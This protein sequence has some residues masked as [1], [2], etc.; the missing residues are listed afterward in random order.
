[1]KGTIVYLKLYKLMFNFNFFIK[2]EKRKKLSYVVELIYQTKL[3]YWRKKHGRSSSSFCIVLLKKEK[4]MW[5]SRH[6][7]YLVFM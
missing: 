2:E 4:W 1:M 6:I 3:F 5:I 7:D